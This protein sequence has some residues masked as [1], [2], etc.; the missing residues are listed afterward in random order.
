MF[1]GVNDYVG[2]TNKGQ[3]SFSKKPFSVELWIYPYT[4]DPLSGG[5][6]RTLIDF[7]T[8][9]W[10]GWLLRR[11]STDNYLS[12]NNVQQLSNGLPPINQWTHIAFTSNGTDGKTYFNG[13]LN[14]SVSSL[15][16]P[17]NSTTAYAIG[18]N[19]E[20]TKKGFAGLIDGVYIWSRALSANE[21]L[22][23]YKEP[24]AMF[25]KR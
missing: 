11:Y 7:E 2:I 23:L 16:Y 12:G 6:A 5:D 10:H 20:N 22:Q 8:A 19:A 14:Y 25:Y 9:G 4:W 18:N 17:D 21:V 15:T 3:F 13:S 1:D 24:F